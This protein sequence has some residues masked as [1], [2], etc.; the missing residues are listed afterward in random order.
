MQS[1][2]VLAFIT[3]KRGKRDEVLRHILAVESTVRKEKGCIEYQTTI[4]FEGDGAAQFKLGNDTFVVIEKWA[5]IEDLDLHRASPHM[6]D[7][8]KKVKDLV[9]KRIIHVTTLPQNSI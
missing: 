5:C 1:V 3:A 9:E 8:G 2:Y 4:D 7:F 6:A